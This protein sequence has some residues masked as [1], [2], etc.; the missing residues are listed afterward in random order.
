MSKSKGSA[1][2]SE[3]ADANSEYVPMIGLEIHTQLNQ[4]KSKLFCGC[5]AQ[6]RGEEPNLY[7]CPFCLGLPGGLP[8][9]NK[10]AVNIA[11]T[12]AHAF[13]SKINKRQYFFR[14]NYFYP[15]L[16]S[17]Y[18]IT[19]Y[20][21]GGGVAF[22]DGGYVSIKLN[23]KE[24]K[25]L[26]DRFHLENDPAKIV[27]MG[28]DITH[29][30]GSLIDYN[31]SGVALVEIV[32]QPVLKTPEEARIFLKKLRSII[33][34]CNVA[35]LS[36]DGAMR[37]DANISIT[38]HARVEVKNINSFKEVER[39]LKWEIT[40]QINALKKGQETVQETRAWNGKITSTLRGKESES[41]Y[42]YF[43]EADLVPLSIDDE[44]IQRAK[45]NM[46]ELPDEK[47]LR[48]QK[49]YG[50]GEYDADVLISEKEISDF[51]EEACKK[52]EYFEDIKNWLINDILGLL[53]DQDKRISDTKL[54]PQLLV[55][56]IKGI[57]DG[58]ITVKIAKKYL[59]DMVNGVTLKSWMKKKGVKKI[60]D[61]GELGKIA[62]KIIGE[63]KQK[64]PEI[65]EDLKKKPKTFQFFVGQMM[66]ATRGQA[67]IAIATKILKEK[68]KDYLS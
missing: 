65:F 19:E 30:K 61:E 34:H 59:P 37:V 13:N 46:P 60:G 12:L 47:I 66:K 23:G 62:D 9:L 22:A 17:G 41:E 21:K 35:D 36:K 4:L 58:T 20:N 38:G 33:S 16:A 2:S 42:R 50:L 27:H 24:K 44:W 56:M 15:D 68:L 49:E 1:R 7:T 63:L 29:S 32:T 26:L 5:N 31:R 57:K 8:M 18:Q 39:A 40:R 64:K 43:P 28:T 54:T 10:E 14:K 3:S 67:D 55:S 45:D 48:F 53:N 11:L 25:V 6:F 52:T 51:Y